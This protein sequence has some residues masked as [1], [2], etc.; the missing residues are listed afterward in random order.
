E[1]A[2]IVVGGTLLLMQSVPLG[3]AVLVGAPVLLVLLDALGRPL[4][5]RAEAEAAAVADA[6]GSAAD[7]L[8]GHRVLAGVQAQD[9]A[10]DRYEGLSRQALRASMRARGHQSALT[11][12][13]DA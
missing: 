10:A 12:G 7:L 6:A 2:A 8:A 4:R 9:V 13:R 1:A 3:V 5:R 11:A